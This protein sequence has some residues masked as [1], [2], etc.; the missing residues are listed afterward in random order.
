MIKTFKTA[1]VV[2]VSVKGAESI[3]DIKVRA[4]SRLVKLS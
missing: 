4:F 2:E 1:L 3:L